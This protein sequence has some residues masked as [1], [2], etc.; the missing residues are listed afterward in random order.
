MSVQFD[1]Q[2]LYT[3]QMNRVTLDL[4]HQFQQLSDLTDVERPVK[5]VSR[6]NVISVQCANT[7]N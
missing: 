7:R 1:R 4:P 3:G 5:V 6:K 2:K